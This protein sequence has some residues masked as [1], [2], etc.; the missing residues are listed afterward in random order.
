MFHHP[1]HSSTTIYSPKQLPKSILTTSRTLYS[2]TL[3]PFSKSPA[4][5]DLLINFLVSLFTPYKNFTSVPF[6][7]GRMCLKQISSHFTTKSHKESLAPLRL[8]CPLVVIAPED[9]TTFVSRQSVRFESLRNGGTLQD[10]R[11]RRQKKHLSFFCCARKKNKRERR[12]RT[13]PRFFVLLFREREILLLLEKTCLSHTTA[14]L[15]SHPSV[16][17][18]TQISLLTE[19]L[20]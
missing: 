12:K 16:S 2:Y 19:F 7:L 3:N 10:N 17:S 11:E 1:S 20:S 14:R 6:N 13:Q 18:F 5:D 8:C 4:R 15:C 9:V